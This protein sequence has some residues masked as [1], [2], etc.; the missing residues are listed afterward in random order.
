MIQ[1]AKT[2]LLSGPRTGCAVRW[3]QRW[4]PPVTSAA[5]LP[6]ASPGGGSP[7][8]HACPRGLSPQPGPCQRQ[9]C[10]QQQ[11]LTI[12]AATKRRHHPAGLGRERTER[13]G[14]RAELTYSFTSKRSRPRPAEL[15]RGALP[16]AHRGTMAAQ[17]ARHA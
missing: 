6:R 14:V 13:L 16:S 15:R 2:S 10:P 1:R 7:P 11:R 5:P 9:G 12:M 8:A 4:R 3:P 17:P